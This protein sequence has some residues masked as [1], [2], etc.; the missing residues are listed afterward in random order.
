MEN[1]ITQKLTEKA[2]LEKSAEEL[3][4]PAKENGTELSAKENQKLSDKELE[5][6]SAGA[7]GIFPP[8]R[9]EL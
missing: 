2:K 4:A 3:V 9:P 6:V 7:V 8:R 1:K 5:K